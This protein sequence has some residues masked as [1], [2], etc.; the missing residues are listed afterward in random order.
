M[1]LICSAHG[2]HV[3]YYSCYNMFF[4]SSQRYHSSFLVVI[5]HMA[6]ESN[7]VLKFSGIIVHC[8]EDELHIQRISYVDVSNVDWSK[9]IITKNQVV[10]TACECF[11]YADEPTKNRMLSYISG[12]STV[13]DWQ[14]A[15]LLYSIIYIKRYNN[16]GEPHWPMR[17]DIGKWNKAIHDALDL[18]ENQ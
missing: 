9:S 3:I 18:I 13:M 12:V 8:E 7:S 14:K 5:S 2:A 11:Q 6:P 15:G 10:S 17:Q 4:H 16:N 1:P